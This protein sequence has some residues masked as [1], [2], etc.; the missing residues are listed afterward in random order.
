MKVNFYPNVRLTSREE[1][2]CRLVI[3]G[4]SAAEIG[5]CLGISARTVDQHCNNVSLKLGSE[6]RAHMVAHLLVRGL[7]VITTADL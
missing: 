3:K 4:L 5:H 1:E 6:N 2:V 7:I